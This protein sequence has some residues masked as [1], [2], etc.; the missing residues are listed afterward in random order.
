[1]KKS[2]VIRDIPKISKYDVYGMKDVTEFFKEYEGY[3]KEKFDE[4]RVFWVKELGEFLEGRMLDFYKAMVSGGEPKYEVVKQ[5]MLDQVKRVKGGVKYRKVND[6]NKA[7][8]RKSE[9]LDMYAQRLE[10]LARKK[11]G[12]EG[13]NENKSLMT[14]FLETIPTAVAE[15]INARRKEKMKWVGERLSWE[16]VLEIVEDREF[17]GNER[18]ESE[19][20]E[21]YSG[22]RG[23]ARAPPAP[24]YKSY[25]DA[26]KE[27]PYEVMVRFL[28]DFYRGGNERQVNVGV[29]S[30][31]VRGSGN[32]QVRRE[33]RY[34]QENAGRG[35]NR[36]DAGNRGVKC[37]RCGK[38]GHVISECRW[39]TGACF[40]CGQVGHLAMHCTDPQRAGCRKCGG[41]D[42][43]MRDCPQGA[44][45]VRTVCGNCGTEG[46]FSRMC[47]APR[48]TCNQCGKVGHVG[49]MC[50][51]VR[52]PGGG[53][54]EQ[55]GRMPVS[56]GM[57]N[58]QGISRSLPSGVG[59]AVNAGGQ[60][61]MTEVANASAPSHQLSGN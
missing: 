34:N 19:S 49:G 24:Q 22:R 50:W 21:V 53:M 26:L 56:Q 14:K 16:E 28:D 51:G 44:R 61:H 3:C 23:D 39:A 29:T 35:V 60:V 30:T 7:R 10:T 25:R 15:F 8:M 13:I 33:S 41:M 1:V 17:E 40:S 18:E 55:G 43:W 57:I 11:F 27:N 2:Y 31:N 45:A 59:N 9:R 20:R 32:G 48:S 54:T 58:G 36:E 46:H 5:R 6:F 12:D 52:R 4:N 37:F 47:R 38:L 42:H